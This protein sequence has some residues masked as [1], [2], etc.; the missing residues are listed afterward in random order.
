MIGGEGIYGVHSRERGSREVI[1]K[2]AAKH[3]AAAPLEMLMRKL[4]SSGTSISPGITM[5]NGKR[6]KVSPVVRLFSCVVPKAELGIE[7]E[8]EGARSAAPGALVRNFQLDQLP[9]PKPIRGLGITAGNVEVSLVRLAWGS[10][11]DKGDNANIGSVA[12]RPEYLPFIHQALSEEAAA[13]HFAHFPKGRVERFQLSGVHD[14]DFLLHDVL[15]GGGMA[16]LRGDP[17]GKTYA[18]SPGFSYPG[19]SGD[20]VRRKGG[21]MRSLSV[22]AEGVAFWVFMGELPNF[23]SHHPGTLVA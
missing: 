12:R 6:P 21:R 1:L 13:R 16:S 9:T 20:A 3:R 11:G 2:L 22:R 18:H 10:S 15:G 14:L 5:M 19:A 8:V 7:V 4:T 23:L 17:Q